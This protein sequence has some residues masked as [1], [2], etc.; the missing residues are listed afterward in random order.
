MLSYEE[1]RQIKWDIFRNKYGHY[2]DEK[3]CN[4][5][6]NYYISNIVHRVRDLFPP[7]GDF[8]NPYIKTLMICDLCLHEKQVL[9][10]VKKRLDKYPVQL[11][12]FPVS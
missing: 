3:K 11:N 4:Y 5:C 10:D 1:E 9:G 6:N 2:P 7:Q 12:L 8:L